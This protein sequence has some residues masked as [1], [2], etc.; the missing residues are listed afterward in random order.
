MA[1]EV[2]F[3]AVNTALKDW[4]QKIV[5][6]IGNDLPRT[7]D[8]EGNLRN[9]IQFEFSKFGFPIVFQIRMAD[10]WRFVDEGRKPGTWPPIDVIRQWIVNKQLAFNTTET[11]RPLHG[12]F[13]KRG[14]KA[15]ITKKQSL[16]S[17][18]ERQLRSLTF[19][20]SRKI[21][22]DGIAPTPFVT[23]T[24]TPDS[25]AELQT[26]LSIAFK[27]DIYVAVVKIANQYKK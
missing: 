6:A 5:D 25:I 26:N 24:L 3:E 22:R 19:L 12:S 16:V 10:Y 23:D 18:S 15:N 8:V 1:M 4:G 27:Q 9:S 14:L 13:P 20:F 21:K 2:E 7:K 17:D 11:L